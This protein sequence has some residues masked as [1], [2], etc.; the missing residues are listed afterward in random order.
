VPLQL[1]T[2]VLVGWVLGPRGLGEWALLMAAGTLLHTALV[3][4]TH[5]AT[6][7]FG[8]EEWLAT[9]GLGRTLGTRLPLLAAGVGAAVLFVWLDP[10]QWMQRG[11]AVESSGTWMVALFGLHAWIAAEAQATLQ[12]TDR[13]RWQAVLAPAAGIAAA[14]ALLA[15]MWVGRRSLEDV[16]IASTVLPIAIWGGA[17]AAC[18]ARSRTMLVAP[19]AT[20]LGRNLRY[21][22]PLLPMFVLGYVSTWGDHV[23]LRSFASVPEVGLFGISYQ[24]MLTLLAA[25]GV[26]TTILLPRLIALE[27][28]APG[29]IRRYVQDEVPT[30]CALWMLATVWLVALAPILVRW[31]T[32][33]E[34]DAAGGLLLVLLVAVPSGVV[35][36]LYTV[37][38]NMQE[39]MGRMLLLALLMALTNVAVSLALIPVL[40]AVGAA[41]GTATSYAVSQ[42]LYVRD[43]H[44]ALAVPSVQVW[45][46][47]AVGLSLGV[48]QVLAGSTVARLLWAVC[49]TLLLAAIARSV[50]CVDDRVVGRVFTG[51][52]SRV[53]EIINRTL[54]AKT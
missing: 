3:N 42:I 9:H 52:L 47:W 51:R 44:V 25:N 17:W 26:L 53:A 15:L 33:P 31:S 35:T 22:A 38:F 18:L 19:D 36:S 48:L 2:T 4:W 8:H 14:A 40:G 45:T 21:A 27:T 16:V 49:A 41:I 37:L 6:V 11:F 39:R 30:I 28:A 10:G 46:L 1:A 5:P 23:L 54:V 20:A 34:F 50:G 13:I 32:G 43:Q 12:A 7:R 29:A 24:F